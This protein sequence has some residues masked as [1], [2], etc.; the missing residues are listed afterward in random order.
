MD[1]KVKINISIQDGCTISTS[2]IM[3]PVE[4][5]QE[6]LSEKLLKQLEWPYN[7]SSNSALLP[8]IVSP[9]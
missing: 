1:V 4:E 6:V 3:G 8:T 2:I 7:Y 5:S 9:A